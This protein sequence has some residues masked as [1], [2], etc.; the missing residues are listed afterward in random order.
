MDSPPEFSEETNC[1]DNRFW[2]S[3]LLN[4]EKYVSVVL[5]HPDCGNFV[6]QLKKTNMLLTPLYHI[7]IENVSN[8]HKVN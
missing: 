5:S 4:C 8:W 1:T 6:Q 7:I 3:G 2:T